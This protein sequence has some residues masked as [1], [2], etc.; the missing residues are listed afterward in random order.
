MLIP[1]LDLD[2]RVHLRHVLPLN[3]RV[4]LALRE[5]YL[6]TLETNFEVVA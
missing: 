2:V 6:P 4:E 1:E 3:S 5:V